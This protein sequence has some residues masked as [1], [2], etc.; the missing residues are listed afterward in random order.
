MPIK[1]GGWWSLKIFAGNKLLQQILQEFCVDLKGSSLNSWPKFISSVIATFGHCFG[2]LATTLIAATLKLYDIPLGR[3][4]SFALEKNSHYYQ[5]CCYT[6][7]KEESLFQ[8]RKQ[9]YHCKTYLALKVRRT[10]RRPLIIIC[11]LW[12]VCINIQTMSIILFSI[13]SNH[14]N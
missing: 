8:N 6:T 10:T 9:S 7:C 2:N 1:V 13:C 4:L 3:A 5:A 14:F 11:F 12:L